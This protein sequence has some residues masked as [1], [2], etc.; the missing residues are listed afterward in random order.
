MNAAALKIP[1]AKTCLVGSVFIWSNKRDR[2]TAAVST[3][4]HSLFSHNCLSIKG[5]DFHLKC[6]F[7]QTAFAPYDVAT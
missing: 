3:F 2:T 5:D 4:K 6:V 1:I 7:L